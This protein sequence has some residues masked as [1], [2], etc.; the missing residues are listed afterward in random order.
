MSFTATLNF[1]FYAS[2]Y[3]YRVREISVPNGPEAGWA[4]GCQVTEL[5]VKNV[6]FIYF[7]RVQKHCSVLMDKMYTK[8]YKNIKVT[9]F[10]NV[11][12]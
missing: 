2:A 9:I 8:K 10:S 6:S 7:S 11:E 3:L 1:Q 4:V 5:H 12:D